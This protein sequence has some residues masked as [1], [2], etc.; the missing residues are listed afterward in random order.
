MDQE[1][2]ILIGEELNMTKVEGE[3]EGVEES[4]KPILV[5]GVPLLRLD[6]LTL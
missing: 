3:W 5:M 2:W 4:Y 6:L 1:V